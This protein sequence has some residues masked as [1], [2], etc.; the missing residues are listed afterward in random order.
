MPTLDEISEL[1]FKPGFHNPETLSLLLG[2]NK[3]QL[4]SLLYP[5]PDSQYAH[6][7]ILKKMERQEAF[8]HLKQS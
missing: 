2:I 5:S 4:L 6:F 3:D 1:F 7:S 8:M